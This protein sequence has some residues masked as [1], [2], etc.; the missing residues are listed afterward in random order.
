[1]CKIVT[2]P[3]RS[4]L[5]TSSQR[6]S[7]LQTSSSDLTTLPDPTFFEGNSTFHEIAQDA[8]LIARRALEA[9]GYV[10]LHGNGSPVQPDQTCLSGDRRDSNLDTVGHRGGR[11]D[12]RGPRSLYPEGKSTT[13]Q[14]VIL[15]RNGKDRF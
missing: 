6:D 14:R 12:S 1:V 4:H 5:L 7:G 8:E 10:G 3:T 15:S 2:E 11:A 13:Y 9:S